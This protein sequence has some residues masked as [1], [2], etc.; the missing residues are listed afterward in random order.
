MSCCQLRRSKLLL[1]TDEFCQINTLFQSVFGYLISLKNYDIFP[2]YICI[3][4]G[5]TDILAYIYCIFIY[6]I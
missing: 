4:G 5:S 3:N 1:L 6:I 2:V